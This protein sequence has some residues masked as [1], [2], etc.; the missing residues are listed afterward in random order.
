[1]QADGL[2]VF[3]T[4]DAGP[5]VKVVCL[6]EHANAARATLEAVDGVNQVMVSALGEA[7]R[8]VESA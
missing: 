7:A 2:D 1:M 6:P 4:M 5:Q 8:L 3:F